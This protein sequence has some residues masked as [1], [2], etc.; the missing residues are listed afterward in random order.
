MSHTRIITTI[1]FFA[2]TAVCLSQNNTLS[3]YSRYGYG[4][5]QSQ[6]FAA[7]QSMGGLGYG[8]RDKRN[9]NPMNPASYTSIDSLTFM[10]DIG[11]S[12]VVDGLNTGDAS[13]TQFTGNLDYVA[14]QFPLWK[15]MAVSFGILPY[16]SVGYDY[17]STS[18][19]D[20]YEEPDSL[21]S[22]KQSF[23]GTGG[24]TQV[25]LGL[26]FDILNRVAIGINGRYM[27]GNIK[28]I[29][30]VTFPEENLYVGTTQTTALYSNSFLC[31]LGLQYHQPIGNDE[32]VIGG[33][34]AFK[35]PMNITSQIT[36]ITNTT[37]T[38]DTKN[39]F[40]YPQTIGVGASYRIGE[41]V[42]VGADYSWQNFKDTRYYGSTDALAN[43][44]KCAI[45]IEYVPK[46][47][48]K[49]YYETMCYRL[50]ANYS[51]SYVKVNG[52]YYNEF[53]ITMGI[54]FPLFSS[55]TTLNLLLEYGQR[56]SVSTTKLLEQYF[57]IGL[58]VSL[59]E[60]WFVKRK[61]N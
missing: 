51:N 59:N 53:A 32:L 13:F 22:V 41:M 8:I 38:D 29:R 24:F 3:P 19:Q 15:F 25:Y 45:G 26:S 42:L 2:I 33:T 30:Q 28:H 50:G 46:V 4:E 21:L 7:T 1:I 18:T 54:G 49:K 36:T 5:L 31:D 6:S 60:R 61:F 37:V 48:S 58:N 35:L 17:T 57:K 16:S 40:D 43:R 20:P 23:Y 34:Y 56:G 9:I 44:S 14:F 11:V 52:A 55:L 47:N 27:F 12:G 39:D 10:M